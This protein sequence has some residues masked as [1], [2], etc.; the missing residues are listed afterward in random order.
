MNYAEMK[1]PE[2]ITYLVEEFGYEKEDLK[3]DAEG[4]PYTN[5][6]LKALI[7]QEEEDAK[8]AESDATRYVSKQSKINDADMITIMNGRSGSLTHR[9]GLS[10]RSW[11]FKDFGQVDKFPYAELLALKNGSPHVLEEC[12]II[13][14]NKDVQE[15]FGLT[16][17]YKNI[18]TPENI[19]Q[20]FKKDVEDLK[21]FV[22]NL[23]QGM[24]STF[25]AKARDL[26]E[27]K[28]LYDT[29]IIDYIEEKFGFSLKDNAPLSDFV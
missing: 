25:I 22:D 5:A 9:S 24:K 19:N 12:W 6:K 2:L 11:R 20:I 17:K 8:E 4:K 16:E 1:K 15:E 14:L 28:Q 13:I 7:V 21:V 10:G 27:S 29:R 23:P 26:A 3:F 18:L